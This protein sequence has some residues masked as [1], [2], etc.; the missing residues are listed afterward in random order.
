MNFT[1]LASLTEVTQQLRSVVRPTV[2]DAG[3]SHERSA[4]PSI[5]PDIAAQVAARR[6]SLAAKRTDA[7]A[8][9][10]VTFG[11]VSRNSTERAASSPDLRAPNTPK[12]EA[13]AAQ[14]ATGM[15]V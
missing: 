5:N 6:A 12:S 2:A 11:G 14:K 10:A 8:Q 4:T 3:V 13:L 15:A 7:L 1:G 9:G